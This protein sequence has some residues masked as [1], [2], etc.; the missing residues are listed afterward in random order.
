MISRPAW[1]FVD[2]APPRWTWFTWEI[3]DPPVP[4]D[5]APLRRSKTSCPTMKTRPATPRVIHTQ[6]GQSGTMPRTPMAST[7]TLASAPEIRPKVLLNVLILRPPTVATVREHP[8]DGRRHVVRGV[9]VSGIGATFAHSGLTSNRVG[10][11]AM[12]GFDCAMPSSRP[13]V[14]SISTKQRIRSMQ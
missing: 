1:L 2:L 5:A 13:S 14:K 12:T 11:E 10:S 4:V 8:F 6:P 7:T 3:G 9:G